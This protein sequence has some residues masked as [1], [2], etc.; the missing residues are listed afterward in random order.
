MSNLVEIATFTY[1][2]ES[3]VLE[4]I[5]QTENIEYYMESNSPVIMGV[6]SRLMV[7]SD[8]A[9]KAIQIIRES[10]FENYLSGFSGEE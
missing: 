4:S 8:D 3:D 2:N 7:N 9:E 6:S 1:P 10:G 5:L